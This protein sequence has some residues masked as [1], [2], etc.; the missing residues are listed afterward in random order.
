L[1]RIDGC[2]S[3]DFGHPSNQRDNCVEAREAQFSLLNH[4]E[5]RVGGTLLLHHRD[6]GRLGLRDVGSARGRSNGG[7]FGL[8]LEGDFVREDFV[9]EHTE[10]LA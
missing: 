2:D 10:D 6:V 3:L 5:T 9:V 4:G 1:G 7:S 8:G